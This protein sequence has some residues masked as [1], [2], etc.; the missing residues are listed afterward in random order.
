MLDAYFEKEITKQE[1]TAM[2]AKYDEQLRRLQL[3]MEQA[4]LRTP[5]ANDADKIRLTLEAVLAGETESEGLYKKLVEQL[6][7][8]RDRHMELKLNNLP[9]IFLFEE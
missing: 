5:A 7:V 9:Q 4:Q 1:M 6:T 8:Y 3:R 2:K